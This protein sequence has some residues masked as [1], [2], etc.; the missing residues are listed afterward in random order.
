MGV[1]GAAIATT[2]SRAAEALLLLLFVVKA[3][4][5][6]QLAL[7]FTINADYT[8][9]RKMASILLPILICEFVWSLGENAYAVIYGRVG[10]DSCAAITLTNPIQSIMIGALTGIAAASGILIGKRLGAGENEE[11]YHDAKRFMKLGFIGSFMISLLIMLM[12]RYYVNIYNVDSEVKTLTT[13]ILYAYAVI[14][15]IKVQ[16]MILGGGVIRSGGKTKY[17]MIIDLVGTWLLGVPLGIVTGL[18]L[19][20][21]IYLVYFILSMEEGVRFI[22]EAVVFRK[23]KW[24][25]NLT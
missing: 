14:A 25:Q 10:T 24:M 4:H 20:L 22:M 19:K 9:Y 3:I 13:Y 18:V 17:I 16:N 2:T 11:A 5:N 8:Y 12:A 23:R 6:K 15:P 1:T 21:P 7:P